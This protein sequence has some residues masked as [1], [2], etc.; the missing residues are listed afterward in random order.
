MSQGTPLIEAEKAKASRQ[1]A[2][3]LYCDPWSL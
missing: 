2:T 3:D 1:M